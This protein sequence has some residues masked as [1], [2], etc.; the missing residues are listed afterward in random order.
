MLEVLMVG[1]SNQQCVQLNSKVQRPLKSRLRIRLSMLYGVAFQIRILAGI[2][3]G[4]GAFKFGCLQFRILE[5]AIA[6]SKNQLL[7]LWLF[8]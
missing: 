8:Y 6:F 5:P 4:S 7:F 3:N 2:S 1:A